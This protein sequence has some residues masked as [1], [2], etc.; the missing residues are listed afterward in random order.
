MDPAK[1]QD[2]NFTT[3]YWNKRWNDGKIGWHQNVTNE[4][5]EKYFDKLV[6]NDGIKTVLF[7]LCGKTIDM[8]WVL[9]QGHNVIGVEGCDLAAKQFFQ[10][11]NIEYKM[12]AINMAPRGALVFSSLDGKI[13]IFVCNF[14]DFRS[15]V[16][17]GQMDAAFDRGSLVAINPTDR[18]KYAKKMAEL[19]VPGGKILVESL[20]YDP[21]VFGG[22]PH[23]VP[24]SHI[25]EIF[26]E[27]FNVEQLEKVVGTDPKYKQQWNI[28]LM[29]K[30]VHLMTRK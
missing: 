1:V 2:N 13:K 20:E 11:N 29:H 23:T 7:P 26:G 19:M 21:H 5:L 6:G 25:R 9:D 12:D 22:P 15:T 8:K 16:A 3:D 14:F 10:E 18:A 17:G 30:C 24:G 4:N 28:D 27:D